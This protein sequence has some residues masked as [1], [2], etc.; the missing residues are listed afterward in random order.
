MLGIHAELD[1]AGL[2]APADD[3]RAAHNTVQLSGAMG[4]GDHGDGCRAFASSSDQDQP[5]G[6]THLASDVLWAAVMF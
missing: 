2:S 4:D 5:R 6:T 3:D 1:V